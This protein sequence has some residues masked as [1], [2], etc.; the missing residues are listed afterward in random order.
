MQKFAGSHFVGSVEGSESYSGEG[1]FRDT[2]NFQCN[3]LIRVRT[4]ALGNLPWKGLRDPFFFL[5]Y[6]FFRHQRKLVLGE[7]LE[8]QIRVDI[9]N[10]SRPSDPL[11]PDDPQRSS[12]LETNDSDQDAGSCRDV[13]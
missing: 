6:Q 11:L 3:S 10:Y 8:E 5:G 2:Q 1:P 13:R 12:K 9:N 7:H 4:Y